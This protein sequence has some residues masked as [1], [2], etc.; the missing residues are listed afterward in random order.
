MPRAA[1]TWPQYV[2]SRGRNQAPGMPSIRCEG[3]VSLPCSAPADAATHDHSGGACGRLTVSFLQSKSHGA[4][5][6]A[7]SAGTGS[8]T[9]WSGSSSESLSGPQWMGQAC[10]GSGHTALV[11]LRLPRERRMQ[12]HFSRRCVGVWVRG[13]MQGGQLI[14]LAWGPAGW[15]GCRAGQVGAGGVGGDGYMDTI[16]GTCAVVGMWRHGGRWMGLRGMQWAARC[17]AVRWSGETVAVLCT[18][19]H[20]IRL[21]SLVSSSPCPVWR[22]RYKGCV[23]KVF[24]HGWNNSPP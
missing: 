1:S 10:D 20:R 6:G 17:V 16:Y 11:L 24:R 4:D 12:G 15:S 23:K 13:L 8:D 7:V 21:F 19:V 5:R 3:A 18:Y 2:P 22:H 14:L 9:V